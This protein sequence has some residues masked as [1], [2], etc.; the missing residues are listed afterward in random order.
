MSI[1]YSNLFESQ[2][3][4]SLHAL[5]TRIPNDPAHCSD[6]SHNYPDYFDHAHISSTI[7][8]LSKK[9]KKKKNMHSILE[10]RI[11]CSNKIILVNFVNFVNNWLKE[12]M[13]HDCE[14]ST[15]VAIAAQQF[16]RI[17]TLARIPNDLLI[18]PTIPII[19]P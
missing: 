7:C 15:R 19:T 9:K 5:S 3:H 14:R 17:T 8:F 16:T 6:N 2:L 11:S 4:H 13:G 12:W 18:A 1:D 10:T